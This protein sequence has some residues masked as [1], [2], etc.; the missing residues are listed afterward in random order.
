M[1]VPMPTR[2]DVAEAERIVAAVAGAYPILYPG[3]SLRY[4]LEQTIAAALSVVR[5]EAQAKHLE[6]L[7]F[8]IGTP[9]TR[10][11]TLEGEVERMRWLAQADINELTNAPPEPLP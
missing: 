9:A 2:A 6:D 7:Q 1:T 8:I 5:E 4:T 11:S 3:T 10:C